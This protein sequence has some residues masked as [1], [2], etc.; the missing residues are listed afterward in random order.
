MKNVHLKT[1]ALII[2]SAGL[3]FSSCDKAE[4]TTDN[5]YRETY[6][7]KAKIVKNVDDDIT[8]SDGNVWHIKGT[9]ELDLNFFGK[10][11]VSF[12]VVLTD[13]DGN[14]HRFKRTI[15]FLPDGNVEI[16]DVV[17]NPDDLSGEYQVLVEIGRE[18]IDEYN[19]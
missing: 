10:N 4:D 13:P 3:L 18:I 8:D 6:T 7:T 12:D 15:T 16:G 9:I 19:N 1:I 17:Y 5:N 2:G 11:T 14:P